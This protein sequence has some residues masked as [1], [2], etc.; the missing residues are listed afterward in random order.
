[1]LTVRKGRL[2]TETIEGKKVSE[3]ISGMPND[4]YIIGIL[5]VS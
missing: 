2:F 1:M 5:S 3:N 4:T